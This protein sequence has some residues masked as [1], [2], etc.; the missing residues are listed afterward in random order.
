MG[1]WGA[2]L[3]TN[4][5]SNKKEGE[6]GNLGTI[7]D[8]HFED[9]SIR[10]ENGVLLAGVGRPIGPIAFKNV[11]VEIAVL[12]NCTC[13]KGFPGTP[14]GCVDYRPL[15][16]QRAGS[17]VYCPQAAAFNGVVLPEQTAGIRMEGAGTVHFKMVSVKYEYKAP[18]TPVRPAYWSP[19][20]VSNPHLNASFDPWPYPQNYSVTGTVECAL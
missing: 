11:S 4:I 6:P 1:L 17:G 3:V 8:V 13:R 18:R 7:R 19:R 5:P 10:A 9:I 15:N 14:A 16:C 20:C 12:G 2:Y